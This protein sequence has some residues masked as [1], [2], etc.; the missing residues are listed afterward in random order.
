MKIE[1][2]SN[3]YQVSQNTNEAESSSANQIRR[4]ISDQFEQ[5]QKNENPRDVDAAIEYI[6]DNFS[7]ESNSTEREIVGKVNAPVVP[8]EALERLRQQL[9][10]ARQK[11]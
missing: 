10:Q 6:K 8:D 5:F 4:A 7:L 9:E 2:G 11:K 1:R 3:P